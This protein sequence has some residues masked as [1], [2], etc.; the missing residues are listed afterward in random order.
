MNVR[1]LLV[2]H[3]N[4]FIAFLYVFTMYTTLSV[5]GYY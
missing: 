1:I 2:L 5:C 3:L 4:E